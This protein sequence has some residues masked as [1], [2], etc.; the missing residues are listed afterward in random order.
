MKNV[1]QGHR[2]P[3]ANPHLVASRVYVIELD[4]GAGRRRDPRIP[5]V[6]V[7]SSARDA[8]HPL[9]PAPPRLPVVRPRQAVRTP[10]PSRPLRG[11]AG[12]P[13][14]SDGPPGRA[15]ACP[16]ARRL[17]VRGSQRRHLLREGRGIAGRSGTPGGSTRSASTPTGPRSN[18]SQSSFTPLDADTLRRA[19]TR[20]SRVLGRRPHRP[21]RSAAGLRAV[22]PRGDRR[23][24]GAGG[25][26]RSRTRPP[27]SPRPGVAAISSTAMGTAP[28]GIARGRRRG[29]RRCLRLRAAATGCGDADGEPATREATLVLDFVP[30]PVHAGIYAGAR[31]RLLRGRGNRPRGHRADLDGRHAE[32]DRRRRGRVRHRRRLDV[33]GQ[34]D[35]G[36]DAQAVMAIAQR[37]ARRRH[38][39]GPLRLRSPADLEGADGRRDRGALRRRN[40]RHG[41]RRRR[42]RTPTPSTG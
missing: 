33:A 26:R 24:P 34:I 11:P 25:G 21:R 38:H 6:Y 19:P 13:G 5:W 15:R 42:R 32:A 40:P 31:R 7:G 4:R 9:R 41:R 18:S 35:A 36:R 28:S 2:S 10:P 16:R 14:L 22:R 23:A 1:L 8:E 37:A 39:A 3:A 17:R 20:R 27:P 29:T 30:G 12:I